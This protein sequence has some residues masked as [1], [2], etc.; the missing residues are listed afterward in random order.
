MVILGRGVAYCGDID[1]VCAKC[2][3][4]CVVLRD[5]GDTGNLGGS[6]V[7]ILGGVPKLWRF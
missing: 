1:T 6:K 5:S 7:V 3:G 2:S 4:N